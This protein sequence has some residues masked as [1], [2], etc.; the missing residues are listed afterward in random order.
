MNTCKGCKY[1]HQ[2]NYPCTRC[3]TYAEYEAIGGEEMDILEEYKGLMKVP[4]LEIEEGATIR[5]TSSG[6]L[7]ILNKNGA[8]TL[9]ID[10]TGMTTP[11]YYINWHELQETIRFVRDFKTFSRGHQY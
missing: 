5:V 3:D 8:P 7:M 4:G 9:T 2:N 1:E 6:V 10:G 11:A